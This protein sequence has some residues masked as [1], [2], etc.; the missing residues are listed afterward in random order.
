ML[1]LIDPAVAILPGQDIPLGEPWQ[2]LQRCSTL[3]AAV[4]QI[5]EIYEFQ[6][7][8]YF[9]WVRSAKVDRSAFIRSQ[10][11]FQSTVEYF[12]QALHSIFDRS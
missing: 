9:I 3:H 8:P 2:C 12:T 6:W 1:Q 5:A 11:P 7:H 10:M 4:E